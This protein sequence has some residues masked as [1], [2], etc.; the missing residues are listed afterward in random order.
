[1][2]SSRSNP[3]PVLFY[4]ECPPPPAVAHLALSFWEFTAR[5][6]RNAPIMHEIFPDGCISLVYRRNDALN[7]RGFSISELHPR[8]IAFPVFNGDLFWGKSKT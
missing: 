8:S 7:I 2:S 6:A 1:M 5:S 4:R 3:E